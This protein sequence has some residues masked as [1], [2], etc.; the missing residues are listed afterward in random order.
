[1][2]SCSDENDHAYYE[3]HRLTLIGLLLSLAAGT[4]MA[5]VVV[6]VSAKNP[7]TTLRLELPCGKQDLIL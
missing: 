3:P 2:I 5:D 1:L 6:V 4:A 7:L